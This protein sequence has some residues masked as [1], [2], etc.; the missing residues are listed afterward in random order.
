MA[1]LEADLPEADKAF[2]VEQH[3]I[4]FIPESERW[5]KPRDLFSMWAGASFQIEY[6]VYGVVLM[7]L[8]LSFTQAVWITIVGNLSFVLLGVTSLQGPDAGTT[9]MTINRAAFGT[10]GS[11]VISLFN[12]A[13]Q[14]CFETEGLILVVLAAEVLAQ[15]AGFLPGT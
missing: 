13:T 12:W 15:K 10:Q 7:T 2:H 14:V 5:A 9:T 3:G 11:R 8:G 4:D 6:F 1:V